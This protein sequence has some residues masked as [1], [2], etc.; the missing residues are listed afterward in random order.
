M[1]GRFAYRPGDLPEDLERWP[2]TGE[3]SNY[4]IVR[5]NPQAYGRIDM[6]TSASQHRLGIWKCT[7]GAFECTERG[8]E[9]QTI[10]QGRMRLIRQDGTVQEFG[11]GDSFFTYKGERVTWDIIEDVTKVFFTHDSDGN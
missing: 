1:T 9:L 3:A 11:P 4:Q 7:A 6:G 2:F 10:L 5:G 8:D